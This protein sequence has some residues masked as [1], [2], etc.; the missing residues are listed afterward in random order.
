MADHSIF[1][2]DRQVRAS[3]GTRLA[4]TVVGDGPRTPVLFVNGWTCSDGYWV[5]IGPRL[6]AAGHPAIYADTRGHGASGLPRSPG[7]AGR[8]LRDEDVSPERIADDF[9]EVLDHAGVDRAAFAG[10][11][12]GVQTIVEVARRHPGRVAALMPIAGTF[13]NPVKT[14]ADK[15]FLNG[16][17]PIAD[18]LFRHVPFELLRPV[19]R[20]TTS[21]SL[22]LKVIRGIKVGGPKVTEEAITPHMVH[23]GEVNFSVLWRMM[24][25]LRGHATADFL[26]SITAPALVLAG[27]RDVF[28]P[29]SV[30]ETMAELI[31]GA[32]IVWFDEGG[33]LLPIEEPEGV[34]DAMVDFLARRVDREA[35]AT[36]STPELSLPPR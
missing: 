32:E 33:H 7:F 24:S 9:V 16:L 36:A 5:H 34:A 27:R 2:K 28:T 17:Y 31:P 22:G 14:F 12:M 29:P 25:G 23:V 21:P 19:I 10:H 3:D 11:S 1:P 4:Y 8:G 26:P 15:A 6:V 18:V 30:Q 20:R 35:E 13:E